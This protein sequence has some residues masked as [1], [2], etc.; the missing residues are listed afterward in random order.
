M[1]EHCLGANHHLQAQQDPD[2]CQ[3][4]IV[5][6]NFG[7]VSRSP[8]TTAV[9]LQVILESFAGR[10]MLYLRTVLGVFQA[11]PALPRDV[12]RHEALRT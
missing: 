1:L 5:M 7:A 3:S 10:S 4:T 8:R 2:S 11:G 9:T 12:A 6:W